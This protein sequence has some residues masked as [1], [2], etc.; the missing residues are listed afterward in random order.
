MDRK[1]K[2]LVHFCN[3]TSVRLK[4]RPSF[5]FYLSPL[6]P[7]IWKSWSV[8][9][10]TLSI[11]NL[12]GSVPTH[13]TNGL[14]FCTG[15]DKQFSSTGAC[16]LAFSWNRIRPGRLALSYNVFSFRCFSSSRNATMRPVWCIYCSLHLEKPKHR[17]SM[18]NWMVLIKF[19]MM[20]ITG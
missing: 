12:I 6:P 20:C 7:R 4:Y 3:C 19:L 17:Q 9:S 5:V 14:L 2:L 18:T 15:P 8:Q 10:A 1:T 11:F 13:R 16:H